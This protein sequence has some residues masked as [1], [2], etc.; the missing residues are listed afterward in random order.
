M[1][2]MSTCVGRLGSRFNLILDPIRREV[3]YGALGLMRQ[4]PAEMIVGL[5]DG[6][7]TFTTLPLSKRGEAPWCLDQ[8]QTMTSVRYEAVCL[9]NGATLE[10]QIVAP[11]WPQDEITSIVPAYV[12]KFRV[13]KRKRVRWSKAE[14]DPAYKGVLRFGIQMP[15]VK[16]AAKDGGIELA[17]DVA[18]AKQVVTGEGGTVRIEHNPRARVTGLSGRA[19][20]RI[21]PL[22]GAW[23]V[24]NGCLEA[25]F[26]FT[27]KKESE[28]Y[29]LALVGYCGDALFERMHK[30]LPLRYTKH[31]ASAAD[32]AAF[33]KKNHRKLVE[34]SADF[35]AVW[36]RSSLPAAAQDLTAMSFQSYLMCTLWAG[37]DAN[38]WFSVWEG[39]CWYNSTVD[40]TYNES[41]LYFACWPQLLEKIFEEWSH[42]VNDIEGERRRRNIVTD[43]EKFGQQGLDFDGA[44][45]E[46]DMGAGWTA[47]GQSY[48]HAM[49]VEENSNFLLMLYAHG[50]WWGRQELYARYNKINRQLVDY[51][52]WSDSTGNG[53]PDRG[54][55]NTIDDA[56]PAVQYGR[57]NVYLG[58]K[59]L[60]AL[61][62]AGRMFEIVGEKDY[63][64]RCVAEVRR[65]V[66]T[67][68]A[69]WL[70]DHW[71][72]CLDKSAKGLVDCWS[73][74]PLP[75]KA[76]PGWNA[77]SL[78]TTN[79]LLPLM[80]ID[81][82][83]PG[84]DPQRLQAD[85]I[86][87]CRESMTRYGCGHSSMDK[88]NM[89][90]S[91]NVWR[92]CAGGYLGENLLANC[93]RYWN[94]QLF[95]NG[96]GSE[97]PNCFTET[98]LTNN[99]VWYPRGTDTFGL[100]MST[101]GLVINRP[102]KTLIV[103]PVAPGRW[104]LLALADWKKGKV[105]Y[106]VVS[107]KGDHLETDIETP[108]KLRD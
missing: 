3:H 48:H 54:T 7:G 104:P 74:K 29:S 16:P 18:V 43:D 60:A 80:M 85:L 12:V 87:A 93:E 50:Q 88:V 77:Y 55:A 81:D 42:H 92:D 64:R 102:E 89:W 34:K 52:F 2:V 6:K 37:K 47:N 59:R 21:V 27:G 73:H 25:A 30:A 26:D 4:T 103:A 41:L 95:G 70:G 108:K 98:S 45:M 35:D 17:Y 46:H 44:I 63:A 40:V 67:L 66:K 22:E 79:G 38:D 8:V 14:K 97:K 56:T 72:V 99:L 20:D 58:I 51:L 83:P 71:G 106:A 23:K 75:Y 76:L 19:R 94:Q 105:P 32:V 65:A 11:F 86:N 24:R 91:M 57:D 62:A 15:G 13:E 31:W 84:I 5:D 78:Y 49:P 61:H 68:N 82:L 100:P 107:N 9:K 33:V 28:E 10:M 69:G 39:S 36:T 90:V 101:A 1:P 53:F 96:V